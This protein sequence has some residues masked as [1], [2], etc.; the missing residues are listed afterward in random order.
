MKAKEQILLAHG[1]GGKLTHE[2]IENLFLRKFFNPILAPLA[3]A[4]LLEAKGVRLAFTTDSYVVKPLFFPGGDIGRLAVFGTVN[5]LS[6]VGAQPLFLSCSLIIEQG[7]DYATLERIVDS[8]QKAAQEAGVNVVTGDTK[9]VERG[10]VDRLYVNTSGVG[11]VADGVYLSVERIEVGDK[12]V[13]SGTIGD[14]GIAVLSEREGFGFH[15]EI[16]SDCAPLNG[17]ISRMLQ[18]SR[19]IKFM[20]DPT[21]GGLATTLNEIVAGADFGILIEEERIPVREEVK[22]ICELLGLDPFYIANEGKVVAVVHPEDAEAVCQVM[23]GHE[24]GHQAAV[25]G[26]V[27]A[28]PRGKVFLRTAIGG[29]RLVDMLVGD[30]LPRIC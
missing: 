15:S 18:A 8:I 7:L 22:S 11:L 17:L 6:V 25:I 21:R 9:V 30:Q 1:S 27:V 24:L 4:A 16:A 3:D 10:N 26:E 28:E 13:L 5:D 19:R 29:T 12:I 20:R 23:W 2:L 14:H